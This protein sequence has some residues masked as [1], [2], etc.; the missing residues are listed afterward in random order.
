[1]NDRFFTVTGTGDSLFVTDFPQEYHSAMHGVA[2]WIGACD[3]RLTNLETNLDD[4]GGCASAYSGGT[5]I[6]TRKECLADLQRFGFNFYGTA[7]NHV[8]DYSY[9]G[10]LSTIGTLDAAG[11]AHAGTGRSLAEA[12]APAVID[13]GGVKAAVFA[14]DCSFADASRAG[15]PT[16]KIGPR[17]G[18]NYLR[19]STRYLVTAQ[20]MA[21]LRRIADETHLNFQKNQSIATG[22]QKPEPEGCFLFGAELFTTDGKLAGS[23][24]NG[25][26]KKRLL[27][28]ITD[29]KEQ[30]DYVFILTHCHGS[31]EV[32]QENPP[33]Y[34]T[35]FARACIDAGCSAVFG[36]GCHSLRGIELYKGFPIFYSLGDFIYQG[37]EV[38]HLPADFMEKWGADV[39]ATAKE[40]LGV[41]SQGG[42]VGLQFQEKNYQ[43]VLPRLRFEKGVMTELTM[44]P[45]S[46]NYRRKDRLN[47][48]P[49]VAEGEEA[50]KVL[51]VV[52]SVSA[53]FGSKWKLA[54]GLILPA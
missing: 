12:A 6:N 34:L 19:H 21:E 18:V 27:Q 32:C 20:Q 5:W 39:N 1:M 46:L 53:A 14:V 30:Y 48:L 50:E 11:L 16:R 17:P 49:V 54:D 24:C 15:N 2:E 52:R 8:M 35:E 51:Q 38:E 13:C 28:A 10:L 9:H 47:G 42:K 44:L 41:R 29:A 22:F 36:G 45:L 26:D 4:F 40:A 25:G 43:S 23:F 33:Q 3:L 37:G 31:D 7:N